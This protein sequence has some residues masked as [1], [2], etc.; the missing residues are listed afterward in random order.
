MFLRIVR[1]GFRGADGL[2]ATQSAQ[3]GAH[4]C[5]SRLGGH[6]DS[7]ASVTHSSRSP[8]KQAKAAFFAG[9]T[10]DSDSEESAT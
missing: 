6:G 1:A 4:F 7:D 2:S 8:K 9:L 3:I 5:S 10:L